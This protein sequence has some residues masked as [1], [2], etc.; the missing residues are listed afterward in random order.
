MAITW[1]NTVLGLSSYQRQGGEIYWSERD[2]IPDPTLSSTVAQTV[3]QGGG[4]KRTKVS[5]EGYGTPAEV[6]AFEADQL[7]VTSRTLTIGF[8]NSFAMA[9]IIV[10]LGIQPQIGAN[11]TSYTMELIEA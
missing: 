9:M 4:K 10:A 5:L 7:A 1:G 3:L 2:L 11:S 6:A 8:D